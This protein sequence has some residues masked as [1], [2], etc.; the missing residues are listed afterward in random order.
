MRLRLMAMVALILPCKNQT[1]YIYIIYTVIVKK[2][3]GDIKE[4]STSRMKIPH[5]VTKI[6]IKNID[7]ALPI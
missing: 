5:S 7:T 2:Y 1:P 4:L 6:G 3:T